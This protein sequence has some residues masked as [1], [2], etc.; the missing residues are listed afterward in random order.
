MIRAGPQGGDRSRPFG[1]V[2][3][4]HR[5]GREDAVVDLPFLKQRHIELV[6]DQGPYDVIGKPRISPQGRQLPRFAAFGGD[7]IRLP[8]PKRERR[9]MIEEE[10]RDVIVIHD[11]EHVRALLRKPGADRLVRLENG[12]PN[13][14][15]GTMPI[16]GE[17]D[18]RGMRSRNSTENS[19]HSSPSGRAPSSAL[20]DSVVR[21]PCGL[22]RRVARR[23]AANGGRYPQFYG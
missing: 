17:P 12:T 7:R 22:S 14:I 16:E 9:V 21:S 13:G 10:R 8:D 5:E 18:R 20:L 2:R 15:V 19:R 3:G 6:G 4:E 11:E 1:F 23:R